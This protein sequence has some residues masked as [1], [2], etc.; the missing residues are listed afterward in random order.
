VPEEIPRPKL[1]IWG[2]A[3]HALVVADAVRAEG[4]YDVA[5]FL[6]DVDASRAGEPYLGSTVLGG[7]ER[8]EALRAD[9]VSHVVVGFHGSPQA[10]R[11][12]ADRAVAAG[13]EL[14]IVIHPSATVAPGVP[15]GA[16]TV[17][18]SAVVVEPGARIG[19]NVILNSTSG[20]GHESVVGDNAHLG[21]R[22][23]LGG[24]ITIGEDVLVELGASITADV[25]IGRGSVIGAGSLVLKDVPPGVLAYGTPARVVREL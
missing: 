2:A 24:R 13:F 6:D 15:V 7:A 5:G 16:G 18:L 22:V 8:L 1:V 4:R 17:M 11:E 9:G 10:R 19:A 12:A 14:A 25:T 23:S 20:V 21:G 3:S